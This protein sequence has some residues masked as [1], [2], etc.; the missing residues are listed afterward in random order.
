MNV[1]SPLSSPAIKTSRDASLR[2]KGARVSFRHRR[3]SSLNYSAQ[4]IG[5]HLRS[6]AVSFI[7]SSLPRVF[8]FNREKRTHVL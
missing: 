7:T 4:C 8:A 3:I 6:S 2:A 5:V 1:D